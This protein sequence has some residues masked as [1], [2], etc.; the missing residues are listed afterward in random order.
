[1]IQFSL[2]LHH[3]KG[4]KCAEDPFNMGM[5]FLHKASFIMGAFSD[6]QHTHPGISHWSRPPGGHI[7]GEKQVL[8]YSVLVENKF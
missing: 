5:F 1:M 2:I 6:P 8:T 3:N 4:I 7:H